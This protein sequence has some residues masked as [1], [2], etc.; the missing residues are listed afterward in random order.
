MIERSESEPPLEIDYDRGWREW[1]DM[2]RWS[3]APFHRRRLMLQLAEDLSFDSILD[4]GC[5]NAEVLPP[6]SGKL[7]PLAWKRSKDRRHLWGGGT[8]WE[9]AVFERVQARDRGSDDGASG[10]AGQGVG[11]G[12]RR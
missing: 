10:A 4:V 3:P 1:G 8:G 2:I 11:P 12:G 5:G 6:V 9:V 7:P